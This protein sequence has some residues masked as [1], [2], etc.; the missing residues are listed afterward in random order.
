MAH[1][2]KRPPISGV[3]SLVWNDKPEAPQR[4]NE[5]VLKGKPRRVNEKGRH[6]QPAG[7]FEA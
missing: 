1:E 4:I 2:G 5:A 7:N 6:E 3:A